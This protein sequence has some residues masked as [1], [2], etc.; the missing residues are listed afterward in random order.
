MVTLY[1]ISSLGHGFFDTLFSKRH[2][3]AAIFGRITVEAVETCDIGYIDDGSSDILEFERTVSLGDDLT[4]IG[5][6]F[7]NSAELS[8]TLR[9]ILQFFF[10]RRIARKRK[11]GGVAERTDLSAGIR[12]YLSS[13]CDESLSVAVK[14]CS[15]ESLNTIT[16]SGAEA[17]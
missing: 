13:N 5:F 6:C 10:K 11:I 4:A 12:R 9:V 17:K 8:A 2:I 16:E 15:P 3:I 14:G 1:A 7:Q